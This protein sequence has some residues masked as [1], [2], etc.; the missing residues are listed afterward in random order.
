MT[1]V[2]SV[3]DFVHTS[4]FQVSPLCEAQTQ[5]TSSAIDVKSAL[6]LLAV[7]ALAS[8]QVHPMHTMITDG[9]SV[10]ALEEPGEGRVLVVDTGASMRCAVLGDNL[11]AMGAKNG[12]SV[13]PYR[14]H[15]G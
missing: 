1:C 10:K 8:P 11:A 5:H 6:D 4:A 2:K 13:R 15:A 12:W 9:E 14:L 7:E 3:V